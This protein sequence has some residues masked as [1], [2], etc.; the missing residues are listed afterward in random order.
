M[1]QTN[2]KS[3]YNLF[4]LWFCSCNSICTS[5]YWCSTTSKACR[6]EGAKVASKIAEG[7]VSAFVSQNQMLDQILEYDDNSNPV[8]WWNIPEFKWWKTIRMASLLIWLS[9]WRF[10]A[11]TTRSEEIKKSQP[12]WLKQIRQKWDYAS[13]HLWDQ[14]IEN[15]ILRF[16]NCKI[17]AENIIGARGKGLT[18]LATLNDG[19]LFIPAISAAGANGWLNSRHLGQSLAHS[20]VEDWTA[21]TWFW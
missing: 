19:R 1:S 8:W 3:Q 14:S 9:L 4:L 6:N 7:W 11:K 10:R 13:L 17:P 12:F 2:Y 18:A 21:W 15:G 16:T 20:G 5:V